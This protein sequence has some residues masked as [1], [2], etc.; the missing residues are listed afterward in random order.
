VA[1]GDDSLV[2]GSASLAIALAA[3]LWPSEVVA[4][5]SGRV[6][7]E[8]FDRAKV[9]AMR[10]S[11]NGSPFPRVPRNLVLAIMKE[12]S[13]FKVGSED[14]S[15]RAQA[16]GGAYGLMGMTALTAQ[17]LAPRIKLWCIGRGPARKGEVVS[18]TCD[19]LLEKYSSLGTTALLDPNVNALFGVFYLDQ[20]GAEFGF[21]NSNVIAAYHEGASRVRKGEAGPH[22]QQYVANVLVWRKDLEGRA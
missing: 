6:N 15:E 8:D 3:W 1:S 4:H 11:G 19:K 9:V 21:N 22:T 7:V 16:R 17:D 12:E 2:L 18:D 20:L 14:H 5:G 13:R 10:W